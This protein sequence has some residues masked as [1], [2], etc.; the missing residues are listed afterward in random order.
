M[1]GEYGALVA[2]WVICHRFGRIDRD[3]VSES[4]SAFPL[5]SIMMRRDAKRPKM[6]NTKTWYCGCGRKPYFQWER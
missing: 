6:K 4:V 3:D 1:I 2:M 5:R